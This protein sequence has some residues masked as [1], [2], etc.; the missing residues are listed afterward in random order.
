MIED[1]R[2][3]ALSIDFGNDITI[4]EFVFAGQ[5]VISYPAITYEE[6]NSTVDIYN[7][8]DLGAT[9]STLALRVYDTDHV[10]FNA[11]VR[12]L[13]DRYTAYAAR[14]GN[15]TF[16]SVILDSVDDMPI[17]KAE[18]KQLFVKNLEFNIVYE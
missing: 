3:D 17:E 1:F 2:T 16:H 9:K 7:G 10:R 8:G 5:K 12:A 4:A 18:Q 11:V 15:T 14:I 6:F 13:L